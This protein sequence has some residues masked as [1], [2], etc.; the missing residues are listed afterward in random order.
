MSCSGVS[1]TFCEKLSIN[2]IKFSDC[3][4]CCCFPRKQK[5]LP[6]GIS[7]L[8]APVVQLPDLAPK[9]LIN[10]CQV[11]LFQPN[12]DNTT[13]Q[14]I[15]AQGTMSNKS[16]LEYI[17][18]EEKNLIGNNIDKLPEHMR[19]LTND[20]YSKTM[21]GN[22]LQMRILYQLKNYLINTYPIFDCTGKCVGGLLVNRPE[23]KGNI[24]NINDYVIKSKK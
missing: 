15:V 6:D 17:G 22:W 5:K 1:I 11:W 9:D 23:N 18:V 20:L 8:E 10:E 16:E 24:A 21:E 7:V 3:P 14:I 19:N 13:F 12:E 2:K 4:S